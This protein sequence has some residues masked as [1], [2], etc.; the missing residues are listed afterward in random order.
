[1]RLENAL[2]EA[3]KDR[4]LQFFKQA[5]ITFMTGKLAFRN[6]ISWPAVDYD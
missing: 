6:R 4:F 2:L 1:M 3:K 5:K